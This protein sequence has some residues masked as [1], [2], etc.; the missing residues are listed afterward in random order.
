[1]RKGLVIT[2]GVALALCVAPSFGEAPIISCLPDIII[3]DFDQSQTADANLFV[4]SDALDLDEYV[5]DLDTSDT[6]LRWSFT[7]TTGDAIRIN[8][9][10]EV[11]PAN[12]LEPGASDIRAGTN[13]FIDLQNVTMT[14]ASTQPVVSTLEFHVSDGSASRS[15][16][17]I[18]TT[19]NTDNST[20]SQGDALVPPVLRTWTF[21]AGDEGWTWFDLQGALGYAVPTHQA[22]GGSLEMVKSTAQTVIT[23][24]G[25]ESPKNPST[26]VQPRVGCIERAKFMLRGTSASAAAMP[27]FRLQALTNHMVFFG[28]AWQPNFATQDYVDTQKVVWATMNVFHIAGREPGATARAYTILSYPF[29][30]VETLT[31]TDTVTYFTCDMLDN[32]P[33][34]NDLG[35]I[36]IDEVT[37]DAIDRPEL[38]A[39]TAVDAFTTSSFAASSWSGSVVNIGAGFNSTNLVVANQSGALVIT[40]ASGNQFFEAVHE[41]T[42]PLALQSESWYRLNWQV[43]ATEAPGDFFGPLVRVAL[44]SQRFIWIAHKDLSGGGLV[45]RFESTP[46]DFELWAV[47]PSA[48]AGGLTEP[49]APIFESWLL[50]SN[51]GF[52]FFKV[53]AGTVRAVALTTEVFDAIP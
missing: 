15:E 37:V 13:G 16:T 19:I 18:V 35:S 6:I 28:G 51:T 12:A 31:S 21:A 50:A 26:G 27:G 30:A 7:E 45:A 3:S 24:G 40:V 44:R 8:G 2:L 47:A 17:V 41:L 22:A 46:T 25:Y 1:M 11:L 34:D 38:G 36:F 52:P 43:S 5:L 42:N 48:Q 20:G 23:F 33:T 9:K 32:I 4:F 14:G 10:S 39:G 53:V 49:M 29:Q